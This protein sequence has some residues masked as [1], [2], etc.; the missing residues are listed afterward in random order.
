MWARGGCR[1]LGEPAHSGLHPFP[2]PP[3]GRRAAQVVLPPRRHPVRWGWA[4]PAP[5]APHRPPRAEG[6]SQGA[7]SPH[8]QMRCGYMPCPGRVHVIRAR[9]RTLPKNY[10]E[11]IVENI[12]AH[13]IHA[14]LVI[15]GFEVGAAAGAWSG[16][17]GLENVFSAWG[18]WGGPSGN[19]VRWLGSHTGQPTGG[20]VGF[21]VVFGFGR[22]FTSSRGLRR[23]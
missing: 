5:R 6:E 23:V 21:S 13:N 7:S 20:A 15:G 10:L 14:L 8:G 3:V 17:A 1:P 4:P 18:H 11:K 9:P 19:P 16:G 2:G 12:R 22:V